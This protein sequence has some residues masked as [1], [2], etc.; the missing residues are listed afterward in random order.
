MVATSTVPPATVV[1]VVPTGFDTVAGRVTA[2]DGSTCDVCLWAARTADQRARGLMGVTDLSGAD[3]MVFRFGA[4]TTSQ[5]W[6]R[7]T[8]TPLSVA[9]FG[10]DGMF[11]SSADMSPCVDGPAT[12]CSRYA[13]AGPYTDAVEVALGELPSLLMTPGARLEVFERPCPLAG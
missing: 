8:P 10:A 13:A 9:F 4:E 3:G 1:G 5:F 6:M 11:V 7:D 2:A 12:A